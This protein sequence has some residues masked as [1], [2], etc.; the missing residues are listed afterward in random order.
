MEG[1]GLIAAYA[2]ELARQLGFD[3]AL[4]ARV[5]LEVEDH[6]REAAAA[7]GGDVAAAQRIVAGFGEPSVIA[8]QFAAA[9]LTGQARALSTVVILATG[10]ALLAMKARL[11]WY[12]AMEW[13]LAD[14][15]KAI[16]G[17][18]GTV[19]RA[20]FWLAVA[21]AIAGWAIT[22]ARPAPVTFDRAHRLR[23][24]G[25]LAIS[26]LAATALLGSAVC[27]GILTVMRLGDAT[28]SARVTVPLLSMAVEI[29]CVAAAAYGAF[30]LTRRLGAAAILLP[31]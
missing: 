24:R 28:A 26:A 15:F 1:A 20:A 17:V 31:R 14:D 2:D 30:R 9:R 10:G 4:A 29:G 11:A 6:L 18:I 16:A 8:A 25:Y 13:R 5:R 12:E 22:A 3:G 23:L 27:D 7:A 21:V 19:D